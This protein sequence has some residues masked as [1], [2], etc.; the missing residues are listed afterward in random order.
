ML[1]TLHSIAALS[2]LCGLHRLLFSKDKFEYEDCP[3]C[4]LRRSHC[5]WLKTEIKRLK[6]EV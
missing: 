2:F 1:D 4:R 6:S 5:T 3:F